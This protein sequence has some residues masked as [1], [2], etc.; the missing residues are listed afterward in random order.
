MNAVGKLNQNDSHIPGH[1]QKHFV[2]AFRLGFFI[3][4]KLKFVKFGDTVNEFSYFNTELFA[5]LNFAD[6]RVF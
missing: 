6:R 1:R 5:H 4:R 2:E 3:R